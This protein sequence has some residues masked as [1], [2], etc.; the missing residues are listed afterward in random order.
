MHTPITIDLRILTR[1]EAADILT[2]GLHYYLPNATRDAAEKVLD[3]LSRNYILLVCP[4]N[5]PHRSGDE[6]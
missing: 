1:Q 2:E 5:Q 3:V 4:D 6:A